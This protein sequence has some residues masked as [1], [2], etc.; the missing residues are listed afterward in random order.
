M[1]LKKNGTLEGKDLEEIGCQSLRCKMRMGELVLLLERL[2]IKYTK[3]QIEKIN[4][5]RRYLQRV[6]RSPALGY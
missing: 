3:K 1:D 5:Y 4:Y 6:T 2:N